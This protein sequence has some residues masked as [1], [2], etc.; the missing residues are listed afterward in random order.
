MRESNPKVEGFAALEIN[1]D[2]DEALVMLAEYGFEE[3]SASEE[4]HKHQIITGRE[5]VE[6]VLRRGHLGRPCDLIP[7]DSAVP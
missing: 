7:H 1:L 6:V 2:E 5:V 4:L 3:A